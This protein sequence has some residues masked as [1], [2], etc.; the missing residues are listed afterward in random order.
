MITQMLPS[1]PMANV[2]TG[3]ALAV[4]ALSHRLNA[5]P[6]SWPPEVIRESG[7]VSYLVGFLLNIC[8][9]QLQNW[10]HFS[11]GQLHLPF[12]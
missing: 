3:G 6:G 10:L 2:L 7:L 1:S 8:H 9:A 5:K 11:P 4:E 12:I